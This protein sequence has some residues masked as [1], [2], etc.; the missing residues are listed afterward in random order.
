MHIRRPEVLTYQFLRL[1]KEQVEF[2]C[3]LNVTFILI[4]V[5]ISA[6]LEFDEKNAVGQN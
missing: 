3:T 4:K 2:A 1:D 6:L 5:V